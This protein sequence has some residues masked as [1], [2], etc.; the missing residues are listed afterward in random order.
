MEGSILVKWRGS[1]EWGLAARLNSFDLGS[2]FHGSEDG[3]RSTTDTP[4]QFGRQRGDAR[5]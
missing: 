2:N 5:E 4:G 3:A 1:T